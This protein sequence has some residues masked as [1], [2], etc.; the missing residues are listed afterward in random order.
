MGR[1]IVTSDRSRRAPLIGAAGATV[2][3]AVPAV[4]LS[5]PAVPCHLRTR[6][7]R[8]VPFDED[9]IDTAVANAAREVGRPGSELAGRVAETVTAELARRAGTGPPSVEDV[10][11]LVE[12][13]LTTSGHPEVARAYVLYRQ[14]R[15]E[16]RHAKAQLGV[17]DELKLGLGA[18]AVL[19]E[20]YLL[21]DRRGKVIESTGQ[22]MERTATFV[23][24][25]EE[26]WQPASAGRWA[27][28]S[29]RRCDA[30]SSCPTRRRS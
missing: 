15:A 4:P 10:Q 20:R 5:Q 29:P 14:G 3:R 27:E 6:D 9:R 23:A 18:V 8:I 2:S 30:S 25:A 11:D 17:R 13:V 12:H 7:G 26:Q 22:L 19:E 21:K 28:P 24:Q 1:Q 16:I